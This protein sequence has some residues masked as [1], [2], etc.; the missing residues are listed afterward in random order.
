MTCT[1]DSEREL[2][3]MLRTGSGHPPGD[4]LPLLGGKLHEALLVLIIDIDLA[5]LTEPADFSL[6]DF[7]YG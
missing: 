3:L 7:F 5:A 2:A 1:L 6:L 4:Y